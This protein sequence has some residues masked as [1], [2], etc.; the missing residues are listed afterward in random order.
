MAPEKPGSS[1]EIIWPFAQ[2]DYVI[3][4]VFCQL[5]KGYLG[6]QIDN[7]WFPLNSQCLNPSDYGKAIDGAKNSKNIKLVKDLNHNRFQKKR[8]NA[9]YFLRVYYP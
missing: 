2:H 1:K 5:S 8:V 9:I 3:G 4:A 7:N 6:N